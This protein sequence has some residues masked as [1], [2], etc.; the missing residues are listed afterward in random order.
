M[1]ALFFSVCRLVGIQSDL[2][3]FDTDA[4]FFFLTPLS[5]GVLFFSVCG[6]VSI[7]SDL[8]IYLFAENAVT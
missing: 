6:L 3:N 2:T 4:S 5:M 1:G 7:Q 8:F